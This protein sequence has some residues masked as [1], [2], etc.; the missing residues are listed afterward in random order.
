MKTPTRNLLQRL[1]CILAMAMAALPAPGSN[2]S[3]WTAVYRHDPDGK[4][5]EGDLNRLI[6][7]VRQGYA[8]RIG[9]G[10]QR[11]RDGRTITL[12]HIATP[13][14]LTVI[15]ETHVSAVI[16]PHPLLE[17]YADIAR[18]KPADPGQIWQCVLTTTG[19]FNA[20]V[21][22]WETGAVIRDWPQRQRMTWFVEYP[23]AG[24]PAQPARKLFQ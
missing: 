14:F 11:H 21:F 16:D 6:D 1:V 18:Q 22:N 24:P 15:D 19:E 7:A 20:R 13:V 8:I 3:G 23:P 12:E 17:G 10:W 5:V 2:S 4:A 9:W